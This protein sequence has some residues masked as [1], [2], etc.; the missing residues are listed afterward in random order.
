MKNTYSTSDVA[1]LIGIHPNTVRLYEDLGL[2]T[3]PERKEN[4]YR[5]FTDFHLIQFR[6]AR[7]AFQVEV[8]QNGLRTQAAAIA[9]TCASGDIDGALLLT[10]RNIR[11]IGEESQNAETAIQ[12]AGQIISGQTHFA[13]P[14]LLT[15]KQTA[16]YLHITVDT[17]RNW[18]R[19][20]LLV[21][22][23]MQDG[24]RVYTS[25]DLEQ[26]IIIRS[27][28]CANYSLASILRMLHALSLN[29]EASIRDVIDTPRP[30]DDI[31]T[32]CDHLLSSLDQAGQNA[33]QIAGLLSELKNLNSLMLSPGQ[34][35]RQGPA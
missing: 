6:I 14:L 22:K 1:K 17:L 15:R 31:L 21:E 9:K 23:R 34:K 30:D 8:L 28:R 29:P 27:L 4:G 3:R 2:I 20:G 12:I 19:N 7:L 18:E 26:L 33:K 24:R 10:D 11:Q 13:N 5:I 16:A 35:E 32:A 25:R